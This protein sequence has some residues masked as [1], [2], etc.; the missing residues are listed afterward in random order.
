MRCRCWFVQAA[1]AA[2]AAVVEQR[3]LLLAAVAAASLAVAAAVTGCCCSLLVELRQ[4]EAHS[5]QPQPP[6]TARAIWLLLPLLPLRCVPSNFF[7][8]QSE[9]Q[10]RARAALLLR[11]N[12][13]PHSLY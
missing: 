7:L 11:S 13:G 6:S 5:I 3:G 10:T 1:A 4:F 9:A 12:E 8:C 2:V